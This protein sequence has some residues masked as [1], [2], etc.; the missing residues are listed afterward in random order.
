MNQVVSLVG[1]SGFVGRAAHRAL[2]KRG[3]RVRAVSAPRLIATEDVAVGYASDH[4]E[5]VKLLSAEFDGSSVVINCA[6]DP[7]ASSRNA[8]KLFG[9]NAALPGLITEAA[10]DAGS[11]RLVHVSSAAVQGAAPMLDASERTHAFSQYAQSKILGEQAVRKAASPPSTV[12]YRPPSVH[13]PERRVTR[14]IRRLALSP[15]AS[16]IAT[17]DSPTPQAHIDNV[18]DAVAELA[19]TSHEPPAVVIHPWE[20]WTTGELMRVFG[21]GREPRRIP[22]V[23]A[24][25]IHRLLR[26]FARNAYLAPNARRV[27]MM[28]FGQKQDTSWLTAQGWRP[29]ASRSAWIRMIAEIDET[30]A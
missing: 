24:P 7:D 29:P 5:A 2:V 19:T 13:S 11:S 1:A 28:W 22:V 25:A 16:V 12:I 6:G 9:A 14:G 30:P 15:L 3:C 20:G 23:A 18:G 4:P 17:G 21:D 10:R 8:A 27:E 26:S